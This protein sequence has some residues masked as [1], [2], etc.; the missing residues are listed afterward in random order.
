MAGTAAAHDSNVNRIHCPNACPE[1]L[2][3]P[4]IGER[5]HPGMTDLLVLFAG[6]A[7]IFAFSW[8]QCGLFFALSKG[9]PVK[10]LRYRWPPEAAA[11]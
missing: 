9:G 6:L 8:R 2:G 11:R 5:Y 1:N 10:G 4:R 3:R 7:S